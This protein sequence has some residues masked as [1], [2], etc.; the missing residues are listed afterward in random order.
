M[1]LAENIR[2]LE[3]E[4]FLQQFGNCRLFIFEGHQA[5]EPTNDQPE[6]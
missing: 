1:L 6:D 5:N 4:N 2:L 3:K